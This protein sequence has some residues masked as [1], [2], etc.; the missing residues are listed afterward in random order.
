MDAAVHN[1]N[2]HSFYSQS[3]AWT[4]GYA[5]TGEPYSYPEATAPNG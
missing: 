4:V 3:G 1:G 5:I 2:R